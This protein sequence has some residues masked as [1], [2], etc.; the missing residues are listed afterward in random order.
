MIVQLL[1]GGVAIGFAYFSH[2]FGLI[3][4]YFSRK[5]HKEDDT[6]IRK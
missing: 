4:K 3:K 2:K 5:N 1:L 6:E